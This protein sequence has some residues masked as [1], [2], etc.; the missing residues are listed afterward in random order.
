MVISYGRVF[1]LN[2]VSACFAGLYQYGSKKV[3][4]R[5]RW[6]TFNWHP[7]LGMQA[8]LQHISTSSYVGTELQ[9]VIIVNLFV[10]AQLVSRF[11]CRNLALFNLI[12]D[13]NAM[14]RYNTMFICVLAQAQQINYF[15]YKH[16]TAKTSIV[17]QSC[18]Y[19]YIAPR[20][21]MIGFSKVTRIK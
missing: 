6:K 10:I 17:G 5:A 13:L 8:E 16:C 19:K 18:N 2:K 11:T 3:S 15:K 14:R 1:S 4:L 12:F 7:K 9:Q 20:H 21:C